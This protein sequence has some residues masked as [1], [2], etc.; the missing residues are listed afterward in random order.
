MGDGNSWDQGQLGN[1]SR[2]RW[3]VAMHATP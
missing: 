2:K 3:P 1:Y